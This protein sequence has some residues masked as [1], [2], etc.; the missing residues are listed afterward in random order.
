MRPGE[1]RLR[2]PVSV[3][4]PRRLMP[5]WIV[6][7]SVGRRRPGWRNAARSACPHAPRPT[8]AA[9]RAEDGA[10][11][12]DDRAASF[13]GRDAAR[14]SAAPVAGPAARRLTVARRGFRLHVVH[15][16]VVMEMLGHST[17][18]LTM[19]VYSHVIPQLQ[20]R[21]GRQ[22]GPSARRLSVATVVA[23]VAGPAGPAIQLTGADSC[24]E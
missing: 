4:D 6:V 24:S 9:R 18:A 21:G 13:H 15:P 20:A 23:T 22:H 19:N 11:S 8:D 16:R 7:R 5:P 14:S 12:P 1:Q 17:I 2:R 3:S 10:L